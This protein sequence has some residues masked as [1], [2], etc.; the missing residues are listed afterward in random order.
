MNCGVDY[1]CGSDPTLL[2]LWWK[3]VATDL[4]RPPAWEPPYAMGATLEK[5][6]KEKRQKKKILAKDEDHGSVEGCCPVFLLLC[7][8]A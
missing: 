2:W 1:R 8:D 5:G 7:L 6:K 3:P 4:I